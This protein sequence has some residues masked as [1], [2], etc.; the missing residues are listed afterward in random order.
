MPQKQT[1]P[2]THTLLPRHPAY[3]CCSLVHSYKVT[4]PRTPHPHTFHQTSIHTCNPEFTNPTLPP[5]SLV[6]VICESAMR[7]WRTLRF[8]RDCPHS[9]VERPG[10]LS[11][12]VF[13]TSDLR[14]CEPRVL[15]GIRGD[16]H[17]DYIRGTNEI[18]V[19]TVLV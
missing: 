12:L 17:S 18:S 4:C 3:N 8:L 11:I 1:P 9:G 6:V 19:G 5:T 13:C 7:E 10:L 15:N 16:D 2:R 14:D